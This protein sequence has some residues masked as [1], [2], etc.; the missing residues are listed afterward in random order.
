MDWWA[1]IQNSNQVCYAALRRWGLC[2]TTLAD[3]MPDELCNVF[4]INYFN[5]LYV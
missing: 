2:S 1:E 3:P 4:L 5:D